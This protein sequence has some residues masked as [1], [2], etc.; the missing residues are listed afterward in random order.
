GGSVHGERDARSV[1]PAP[2]R[3]KFAVVRPNPGA[4]LE[5]GYH[6]QVA[7]REVGFVLGVTG[8]PIEHGK[9]QLTLA[10]ARIR[11]DRQLG[12]E[13]AQPLPLGG[14][15]QMKTRLGEDGATDHQGPPAQPMEI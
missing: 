3:T 4:S 9:P 5:T 6:G 1:A 7:V 14:A 2:R 12:Q 10:V 11:D 15:S 8:E 13:T